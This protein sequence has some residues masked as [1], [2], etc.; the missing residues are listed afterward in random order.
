MMMKTMMTMTEME[1]RNNPIPVAVVITAAGSSTRM[2]GQ[3]KEYRRLGSGSATV[4]STATE[5]FVSA[6]APHILFD[7]VENLQ[8]NS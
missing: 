3:K 4:L 8:Q 1:T 6:L 7:K 5:A 2:G